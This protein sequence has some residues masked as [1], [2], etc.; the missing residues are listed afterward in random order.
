MPHRLFTVIALTLAASGSAHADDDTVSSYEARAAAVA[1]HGGIATPLGF[2]GVSLQFSPLAAVAVEVGLGFGFTGVQLA[3]DLHFR[4]PLGNFAPFVSLGASVSTGKLDQDIG[5]E[6][7]GVVMDNPVWLN[8]MV[9]L[10]YRWSGGVEL[11]LYGGY[12]KVVGY[13]S[14]KPGYQDSDARC[15]DGYPGL[16]LALG[17]AF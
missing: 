3:G 10:E 4:L 11:R 8:A 16:G 15:E 6:G 9:G 1:L 13:A 14:C 17:Y 2:G 7:Y 5:A 12:G